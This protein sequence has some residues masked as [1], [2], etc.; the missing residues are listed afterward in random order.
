MHQF[1]RIPLVFF[2]FLIIAA[3]QSCDKK[4]DNPDVITLIVQAPWKFGKATA[5]GTNVS[6]F[7]ESCLKDNLL[8]FQKG[9]PKNTGTVNEGA[10]KC[11]P[12][13]PQMVDF[14]WDYDANF[15]KMTLTGVG[16]G[17]VPILP[18]GSNEFTLVRVSQTEMVLSQN[19]SFAGTTQLVEVTLV[20]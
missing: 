10:T 1:K 18:G 17:S 7:I 13:D 20:P 5:S 8:I 3:V 6:A 19:V 12:M 16:G 4:E 9:T 11:N 15:K 2:F 14:N